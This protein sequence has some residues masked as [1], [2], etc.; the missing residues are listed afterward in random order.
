MEILQ[1]IL[2]ALAALFAVWILY[3]KFFKKEKKAKSCGHDN[4][5]C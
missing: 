5:G 2:V 1:N 4:C 3:A